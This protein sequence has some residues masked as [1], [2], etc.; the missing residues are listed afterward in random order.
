MWPLQSGR[1]R[2]RWGWLGGHPA[3]F[4]MLENTLSKVS[5]LTGRYGVCYVRLE[6]ALMIV[7]MVVRQT[8]EVRG[9]W[10]CMW[11]VRS[12]FF[13]SQNVESA[14]CTH[15][16]KIQAL[17]KVKGQKVDDA[18]R[19]T[20]SCCLSY[21][22]GLLYASK[23]PLYPCQSSTLPSPLVINFFMW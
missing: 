10:R 5:G 14:I 7:M 2:W 18:L 8:M 23:I 16:G 21:R 11:A 15:I 6:R 13:Y 12:L 20:P 17:L 9:R 22:R 4:F 1:G 19:W 3:P